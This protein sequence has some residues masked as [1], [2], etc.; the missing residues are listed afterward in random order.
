LKIQSAPY[1][2]AARALGCSRWQ[3]LLKHLL[4]ALPPFIIS[5]SLISA[6]LFLL[7]EVT[8]SFL[9]V[10]FRDSGESWGTMLRALMDPRVLTDYWWNLAPLGCVFLTLYL[11]N[12]LSLRWQWK[13]PQ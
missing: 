10:G 9:N 7:G 1:V 13:Q 12:V 6:P 5:Q 3:I 11:L 2:E 4:P 8:L